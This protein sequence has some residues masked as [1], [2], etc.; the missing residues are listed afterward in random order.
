MVISKLWIGK[1]LVGIGRGLILRNYPGTRLEG[2]RKT[3]EN[4]SQDSLSWGRDLNPRP[5]GYESRVR[6]RRHVTEFEQNASEIQNR[7]VITAPV[8]YG[9]LVI[10]WLSVVV[11]QTNHILLLKNDKRP[12]N[13]WW[14]KTYFSAQQV[15]SK[16]WTPSAAAK[17]CQ[18]AWHIE[19]SRY[20]E[21]RVQALFQ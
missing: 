2:L 16:R 19:L 3:T 5:S 9:I 8:L 11:I 14:N 12:S 15:K 21:C 20:G 7:F 10:T 4:L 6:T 1:G 17:V 18:A 13:I